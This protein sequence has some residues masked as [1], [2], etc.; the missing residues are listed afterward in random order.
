MS[1]YPVQKEGAEPVLCDID[2][3]LILLTQKGL[4]LAPRPYHLLGVM[5]GISGEEVMHRLE[6]MLVSGKIRRIAAVPNHYALGYRSNGMT[7]WDVPD[8]KVRELG[9]ALGALPFVSHCYHRPRHPPLWSYNLFAMVH[10]KKRREVERHIAEI[11][12]LLGEHCRASDVL[13]STKILK[14]TG[15]R[16]NRKNEKD[17]IPLCAQDSL[18]NKKGD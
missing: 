10:G 17:Q 3:E 14:K 7:V 15:L 4:P 16:I 12:K 2:R 1:S 9:Q 11:T 8:E 5:L 6:V 13:Y 18:N